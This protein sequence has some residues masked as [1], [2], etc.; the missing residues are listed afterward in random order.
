MNKFT[1]AERALLHL[2]RYRHVSPAIEI[3]APREMTQTGVAEALGISRSHAS[4]ITAR[5]EQ[6]G[7]IYAG[8]SRIIGQNRGGEEDLLH[9]ASRQ[10]DLRGAQTHDGGPG[11]HGGRPPRTVQH[12]LL[13]LFRVLVAPSGGEG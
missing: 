6:E 13:Q 1:L 7:K 2:Y 5:L 9:H 12:Q 11:D 4:L 10:G 8:K 3:D